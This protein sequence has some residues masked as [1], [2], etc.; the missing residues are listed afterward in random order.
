MA[1]E[2]FGIEVAIVA[3]Q[4]VD[5]GAA[6]VDKV[7]AGMETHAKS[8]GAAI[9][10]AIGGGFD[11][12]A[13]EAEAAIRAFQ[14]DAVGAFGAIKK[15]IDADRAAMKAFDDDAMAA[16]RSVKTSTAALAGDFRKLE[17]AT[18]ANVKAEHDYA[19]AAKTVEA[20]V[21]AGVIAEER[22]LAVLREKAKALEHYTVIQQEQVEVGKKG[23][24]DYKESAKGVIKTVSDIGGAMNAVTQ[25]IQI[26]AAAM[27]VL[28]NAADV[29]FGK[30]QRNLKGFRGMSAWQSEAVDMS[31]DESTTA[32]EVEFLDA[33]GLGGIAG[34]K[35]FDAAIDQLQA[36]TATWI[37]EEKAS[38]ERMAAAGKSHSDF[39][40]AKR[41]DEQERSVA[42]AGENTEKQR[43]I[44]DEVE[45]GWARA[46]EREK[47]DRAAA[48]RAAAKPWEGASP[49]DELAADIGT[50]NDAFETM[51]EHLNEIAAFQQSAV[52]LGEVLRDTFV[53][54]GNDLAI[55]ADDLTATT[56]E[57][58]GLDP[59]K[60]REKVT[61]QAPP[62][63]EWKEFADALEGPVGSAIDGLI[64]GM[65]KWEMSWK[66]WASTAL[67]EIAK[68]L[69]RLLL[70]QLVEAGF[71][72]GGGTSKLGRMLV[73]SL[74][75][76]P[77]G[78]SRRIAPGDTFGGGA[79]NAGGA[80]FRDP[81]RSGGGSSGKPGGGVTVI[82]KTIVV[83]DMRAA[84]LEAMAS[85]EG[86]RINVVNISKNQG[87][88]GMGR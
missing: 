63:D 13:A 51:I 22:G 81:V 43:K 38:A 52:D 41:R 46:Q 86:E 82:N 60:F 29:A 24:A 58:V 70:L 66:S 30:A 80:V 42:L 71:G 19:A 85:A 37:V 65:L 59:K 26:G 35:M 36:N 67:A 50:A 69:T 33:G 87:K 27:D 75:G 8:T 5:A 6:K 4:K 32:E 1:N 20:A 55:I 40:L 45:K 53:D 78:D 25:A 34:D 12:A 88:L 39:L 74:G 9:E 47:A 76:T 15:S 57:S 56:G 68:V 48:A 77:N 79:G 62:T 10:E 54:L 84:A 72:A 17:I 28:G 64:D 83:A 16:L 2:E 31:N 18:L 14:S 3:G 11:K 61:I 23:W 73:G 21:R 49:W 7:L 44:R